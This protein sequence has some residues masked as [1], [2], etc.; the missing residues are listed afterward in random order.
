M[1]KL[2]S[3]INTRMPR[4]CLHGKCHLVF[5]WL[6]ILPWQI[7]LCSWYKNSFTTFINHWVVFWVAMGMG[8]GS[9]QEIF[10]L[11]MKVFGPTLPPKP[12]PTQPKKNIINP[13]WEWSWGDHSLP[14]VTKMTTNFNIAKQGHNSIPK[15][16]LQLAS[17]AN[18]FL[19][20]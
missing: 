20:H 3:A 5:S 7:W 4:R 11:P 16:P 17:K 9:H 12:N 13:G 14:K 1:Q 2:A 6:F 10:R 19:T 8:G 15:F 18:L